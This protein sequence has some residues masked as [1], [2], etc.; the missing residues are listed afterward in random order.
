[1]L[2]KIEKE[3]RKKQTNDNNDASALKRNKRPG[4]RFNGCF[5]ILCVHPI[6]LQLI[7]CNTTVF[8]GKGLLI[9]QLLSMS[10]HRSLKKSANVQ[11]FKKN[12]ATMSNVFRLPRLC[13]VPLSLSQLP[14]FRAARLE[15]HAL[16]ATMHNEQR[17][18]A[19]RQQCKFLTFFTQ[20]LSQTK[21]NNTSAGGY[22]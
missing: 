3:T 12:I 16:A 9:F 11:C 5:A 17:K 10:M 8:F 22:I 6:Q 1:M 18:E 7:D 14:V 4:E 13:I 2:K 21:C 15:N 19:C 20:N